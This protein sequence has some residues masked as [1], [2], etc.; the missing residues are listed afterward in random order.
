MT[1]KRVIFGCFLTFF[2]PQLDWPFWPKSGGHFL[3]LFGSFL[4]PFWS[5]LMDFDVLVRK[6]RFITGKSTFWSFLT[7]ILTI[8]SK[9]SRLFQIHGY[10]KD[11]FMDLDHFHVKPQNGSFW[12]FQN[13]SQK[14]V[15]F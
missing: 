11:D 2:G 4:T 12:G 10:K 15:I 13:V 8:Y 7:K 6:T 9:V 1:Q 14:G 5:F 3:T